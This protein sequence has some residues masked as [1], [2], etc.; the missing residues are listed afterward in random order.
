MEAVWRSCGGLGSVQIC[1]PRRAEHIPATPDRTDLRR[2]PV[3]QRSTDAAQIGSYLKSPAKSASGQGVCGG[4]MSPP[5]GTCETRHVKSGS[6]K[7][8]VAGQVSD[9]TSGA[10]ETPL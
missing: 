6:E 3:Q 8:V 1:N 5:N 7:R 2:P 4:D 9:I 10:A